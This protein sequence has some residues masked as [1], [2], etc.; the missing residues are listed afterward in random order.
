M[1]R[2]PTRRRCASR[3]VQQANAPSRAFR[4]HPA[5]CKAPCCEALHEGGYLARKA[6]GR[7]RRSRAHNLDFLLEV[8]VIDPVVE[9][10]ALECVVDLAGPVRGDDHEG[11]V[12]GLDGA[13]L[14]NRHL[15]VGEQLE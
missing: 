7:L 11:S 15:E 3:R 1:S 13:D 6:V 8:W 14:W 12:L 5:P 2:P 4:R 9:A 10:A